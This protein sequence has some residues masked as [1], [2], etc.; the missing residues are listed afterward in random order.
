MFAARSVTRQDPTVNAA[1][2]V[3]VPVSSGTRVSV[4]NSVKEIPVSVVKTQSSVGKFRVSVVK[5]ATE[6]PVSALSL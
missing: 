6:E 2:F 4:V 1:Q 3:S 5:S